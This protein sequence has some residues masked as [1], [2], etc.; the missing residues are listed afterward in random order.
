MKKQ[1]EDLKSAKTSGQ[2]TP[3]GC[4][5]NKQASFKHLRK[6]TFVPRVSLLDDLEPHSLLNQSKMGGFYNM[7]YVMALY[8]F[9]ISPII[10]Y[11]ENGYWIET[12][13]FE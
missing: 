6:H 8:Y 11:K 4:S 7:L 3:D 13:L 1:K 2:T 10:C 5:A 12:K 9:I